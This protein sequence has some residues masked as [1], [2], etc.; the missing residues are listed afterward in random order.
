MLWSGLVWSGLVWSGL[1]FTALRMVCQPPWQ[2]F[3]THS[4]YRIFASSSRAQT[5]GEQN[6]L[7]ISVGSHKK[8]AAQTMCLYS[9]KI[10]QRLRISINSLPVMVSF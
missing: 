1:Q 10:P 7:S 2:N 9:S 4:V 6:L 5:Q 8:A 3:L